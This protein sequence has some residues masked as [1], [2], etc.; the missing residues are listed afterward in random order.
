MEEKK[1]D[2]TAPGGQ[3]KEKR[4]NKNHVIIAVLIILVIAAY[5]FYSYNLPDKRLARAL[6]D[7]DAMM[8]AENYQEASAAYE[9]AQRI[10]GVSPEALE[11]QIL[12]E[13]HITD[14]M[15]A[16]ASDIPSRSR[17]CGRYAFVAKLC[18]DAMADVQ[19]SSDVRFTRPKAYAEQNRTAILQGI[20]AD[21]EKVNCT[22]ETQDRSGAVNLPDGSQI[23]YD[24]YYD[25]AKV[26]DEYYPCSDIIDTA[27]K[28]KM[29]EYF[30]DSDNDI[31]SVV[32]SAGGTAKDA[33]YRDYV[34]VEG[35][36]SGNGLLCVRMAHV[37]IPGNT[38]NNDYCGMTFRLSDGAQVTLPEMVDMT[39]IGLRR[40]A[41]RTIWSWVEN[42][43]YTDIEKSDVEDYVE[44]LDPAEYKFCFQDDG[45]L[46]LIVD[47][48]AP[49]FAE[50]EEIL[51]IPLELEEENKE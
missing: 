41:R 15:A 10:N 7:A 5:C 37:Q 2:L 48:T 49:F 38:Q 43:G 44:D 45:T 26:E 22:V 36:Y 23:P 11:G 24:W 31:A 18:D 25:L 14:A 20:A 40:A 13:L 9:A 17:V 47:Q 35:F 39:D 1:N 28:Q 4:F 19:D 46:C 6:K 3:E 12:A 42:Q 16:E 51:E 34:G 29:D 33:V 21:Y 8:Q 32:E 50:R 30:A 27:L